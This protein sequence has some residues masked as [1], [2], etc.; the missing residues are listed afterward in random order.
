MAEDELFQR[1]AAV[2]RFNRFY[3]KQIG[4]LQEGLLQSPFSLTEARVI[5]ELA[6]Q[7]KTTATDLSLGLDAGYLAVCCKASKSAG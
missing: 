4:L 5:Y 6:Q 2:R 1:V 3:T 7:E